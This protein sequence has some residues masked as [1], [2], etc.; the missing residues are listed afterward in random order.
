MSGVCMPPSNG[1]FITNTSPGVSVVAEALEQRA[2]RGGDRAEVQRDRDRLRDRLAGRVA[3]RG[4]EVH[5][6]AHD[7]RVRGAE[8]RRRHLVGDRGERVADDLLHDRVGVIDVAPRRLGDAAVSVSTPPAVAL[9]RPAGRDDD[10]RVVLVDQQR[11]RPR[12]PR[13]SRRARRTGVSIAPCASPKSA[14]PR[15]RRLA[16]ATATRSSELSRGGPEQPRAA[17]RGSRPASPPRGAR[18]RRAR[19]RPRSAPR[20]PRPTRRRSPRRGSRPR[21]PSSARRSG[22]RRCAATR[23]RRPSRRSRPLAHLGLERAQRRRGPV[24]S[25]RDVAEAHVVELGAG[26]QQPGRREEARERRHDHRAH[27]ELGGEPRGVDRPRAAV[28][29]EREL[30]RVAALLRR[31]RPQRAHHRRVREAVDAARDLD[32]REPERRPPAAPARPPRARRRPRGRRSRAGRSGCSRARRSRRS[33]SA[34]CRR[35]R[36]R[37]APARRPRSAA[38]RAA[39]RPRRARRR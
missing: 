32:R 20:A 6:V 1:S 7:R 13:R 25:A 26:E 12:R 3:E 39:R 27:A 18:R 29:D 14:Q 37:Q 8:D 9:H 30:A 24:S 23:P 10:G 33:R 28:R 5:H 4:G 2:H 35:G 22:G 16:A 21:C 36:S 19:A 38:R 34:R 11:A 15:R 31:D 17:A